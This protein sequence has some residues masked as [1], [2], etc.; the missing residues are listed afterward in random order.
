MAVGAAVTAVFL[1]TNNVYSPN[2][3]LWIVPF[4]VLLPFTRRHWWTFFVADLGIF[5]LVFGRFHGLWDLGTVRVALPAFVAIRAITLVWLIVVAIRPTSDEAASPT[6][7][8]DLANGENADEMPSLR[9]HHESPAGTG[10][11]TS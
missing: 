5:T 2:Y 10:P 11:N 6:T 7:A 8:I 9:S 4:F 3:D 1:L